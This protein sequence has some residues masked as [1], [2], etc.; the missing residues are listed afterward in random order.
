MRL[1]CVDRRILFYSDVYQVSLPDFFIG[2]LLG[3][4]GQC[5]VVDP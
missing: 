1:G 3:A 2:G 4:A 5:S